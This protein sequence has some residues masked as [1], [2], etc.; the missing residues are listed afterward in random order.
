M[1]TF[2]AAKNSAI[3]D[4]RNKNHCNKTLL[5]DILEK[6]NRLLE[7]NE[8]IENSFDQN[9][10]EF[11]KEIEEKQQKFNHIIDEIA[12]EQKI[13]ELLNP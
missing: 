2:L 5:D 1:V 10:K 9:D 3:P 12:H 4:C 13:I 7:L 6:L 8:Q 11:N